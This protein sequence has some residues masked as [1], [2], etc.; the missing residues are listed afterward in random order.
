MS[1]LR[2]SILPILLLLC[3][4]APA[5]AQAQGSDLKVGFVNVGQVI[6]QAPWLFIPAGFVVVAVLAFTVIGDGL[7]D[8]ADPYSESR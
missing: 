5:N 8:A 3:L 4:T 1:A 2:L 6:E 7:R